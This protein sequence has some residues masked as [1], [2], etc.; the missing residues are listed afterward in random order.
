MP[1][2]EDDAVQVQALEALAQ[3]VADGAAWLL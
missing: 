3:A 2:G 1:G